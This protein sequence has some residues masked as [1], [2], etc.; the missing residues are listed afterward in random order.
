MDYKTALLTMQAGHPVRKGNKVYF[1]PST[2]Q[3]TEENIRYIYLD[4]E[5]HPSDIDSKDKEATDWKTL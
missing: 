5:P 1:I 4:D 3:P 2:A